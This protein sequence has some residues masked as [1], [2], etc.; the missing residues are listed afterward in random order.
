MTYANA[1]GWRKATV[2][3]GFCA[4]LAGQC[5]MVPGF[6]LVWQQAFVVAL[7]LKHQCVC[8]PGFSVIDR[9]GQGC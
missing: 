7:L 3:Q 8:V 2:F 6:L 1:G 5:V 4:S 9:Q